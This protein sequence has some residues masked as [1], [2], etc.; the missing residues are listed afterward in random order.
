MPSDPTQYSHYW[1]SPAAFE[2]QAFSENTA[3]AVQCND[4]FWTFFFWANFIASIVAFGVAWHNKGEIGEVS[5]DG[6]GTKIDSKMVTCLFVGLAIAVG[7]NIVH[8]CYVNCAPLFYIKFGFFVGIVISILTVIYAMVV[9]LTWAIVFPIFAAIFSLVL[10]CICKQYFH[11]SAAVL[12]QS[13]LIIKRY[14]SIIALCFL[15]TLVEVAV[16]VVFSLA[17]YAVEACHWPRWVYV[18]FLFSY[19]WISLTF[20]YVMYLTIAGLAASWYFLNDTE[21]FPQYPVAS[22][23]KRA[24]TTSFGSA[25]IAGF[26]L[27]VIQTLRALTQSHRSGNSAAEILRCIALC[28]L[29]ILECCI[30]MINRY[31]LIYCA[32]FGVPFAEGCRRWMELSTNR[33]AEVLIGHVCINQALTYNG[34]IFSIG[35]ALLGYGIGYGMFE[36]EFGEDA[37][38]TAIGL[39]VFSVLFTF[40]IFAVL[41]EP[42]LVTSDTLLVCFAE[43]P[44]RLSSSAAELAQ[45]LAD[46]YEKEVPDV[47][48]QRRQ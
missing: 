17:F 3:Q 35:A 29:A 34:I 2:P 42:V 6:T 37:R 44:E 47:L 11:L 16:A 1:E 27:A 32:V 5:V 8:Y 43:A 20:G 21:F 4:L 36:G 31:A 15:E 45:L 13:C 9:G 22:S 46:V 33:F 10:Y 28:L 38:T 12:K 25:A 19:F 30:K 18:Y 39:C 23:L 7:I 41:S 26:L 40:A 48:A 14:P 24:C